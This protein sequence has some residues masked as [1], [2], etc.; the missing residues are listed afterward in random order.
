M[1]ELDFDGELLVGRYFGHRGAL[2]L[3]LTVINFHGWKFELKFRTV[4]L[5]LFKITF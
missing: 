4:A 5:Y 1:N 2:E 3:N